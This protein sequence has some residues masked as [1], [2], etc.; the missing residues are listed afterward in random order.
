M[1]CHLSGSL[2]RCLPSL[3]LCGLC[4]TLLFPSGQRILEI[5][6][7]KSLD[8][9]ICLVHIRRERSNL[10]PQILNSFVAR[11]AITVSLSSFQRRWP[12]LK[13]LYDFAK[14]S[15]HCIHVRHHICI[16]KPDLHS[17]KKGAF[18]A[19][20]SSPSGHE[21]PSFEVA[22]QSTEGGAT[23][24]K[25]CLRVR[26]IA[27]IPFFFL[28]TSCLPIVPPHQ[29]CECNRQQRKK[30]LNPCCSRAFDEE[31][32]APTV[33]VCPTKIIIHVDPYLLFAD[34]DASFTQPAPSQGVAA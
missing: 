18:H 13:K 25:S 14:P 9:V 31:P 15:N 6:L 21:L 22:F 5:L 8:R 24:G 29:K 11:P 10:L 30:R 32:L 2:I 1:T 28:K 17:I 27:L 19:L 3:G 26:H 7:L 20:N 12:D 4:G 34:K 33:Q 23:Q 16:R